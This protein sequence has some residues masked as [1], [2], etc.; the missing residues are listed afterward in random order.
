MVGYGDKQQHGHLWHEHNAVRKYE[1]FST[2]ETAFRGTTYAA[3][4]I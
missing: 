2:W 1:F 3:W 4:V